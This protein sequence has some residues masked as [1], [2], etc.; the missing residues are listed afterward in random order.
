[1]DLDEMRLVLRGGSVIDWVRLHF[2]NDE[3]IDAFFRVNEFDPEHPADRNRLLTL[4]QKALDYL[5]HHLRYKMPDVIRDGDARMLVRYASQTRGRRVHRFSACLTLKVM[6]I[7]HH[8]EAFEL[9][10]F[11]PLSHME[12]GVLLQA[13]I[14]RVVRGLLER[15]FP[16]VEFKGNFKTQDSVITKLLAKRDTQSAQIFDRLRFR[17]IVDRREDIPPVVLALI[18]E[19]VPFNY[20]V[21]GQTHNSLVDLDRMLFRAG[22]PLVIKTESK[23]EELSFNEEPIV[24]PSDD[25]RNEYSGPEYRVVNFV[26]DVPVRL[27]RVLPQMAEKFR[28][29][30]PVVFGIVEFQVVDSTSEYKN[31]IGENRHSL[32]KARQRTVVKQR[33]ERGRRSNHKPQKESEEEP[34]E[35]NRG[36]K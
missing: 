24:N 5:E 25:R 28:E 4:K 14:E 6:H 11:L 18:R 12:L 21:P 26:G 36:A 20:I 34:V 19:L 32:Y 3:E 35:A 27:D 23:K 10:S 2:Q 15:D 30:G 29:L 13:K 17:L 7:I 8:A 22:N 31:E 9:L 16:I 1:M 33:L